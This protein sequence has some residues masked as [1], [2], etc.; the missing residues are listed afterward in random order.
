M[1]DIT[2]RRIAS[3][4]LRRDRPLVICDVD[5]VV[6]HFVRGFEAFLGERG[7]WLDPRSYEFE[8]NVRRKE[9]GEVIENDELFRL[10][11]EFFAARVGELDAIE[12]AAEALERLASE[13]EIVMLT[14]LPHEHYEE[15]RANLLRHGM[16]YPL[17][18]NRGP[19]GPAV[20]AMAAAR[21]EPCVLVDDYTDFLESARSHHP[22]TALIHFLHDPRFAA[23]ARPVRSEHVR[24]DGWRG[25]ERAIRKMLDSAMT[26]NVAAEDGSRVP[27]ERKG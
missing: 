20:R 4:D 7:M 10:L 15:R 16:P 1:D 13:C 22:G 8:G 2:A 11:G 6:L 14:N 17:V 24:V 3:L 19:K 23:H 26:G 27:M 18:T 21:G 12:G 9:T 5:E 25:A